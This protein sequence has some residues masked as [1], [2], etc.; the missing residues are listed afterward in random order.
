LRA[1]NDV[2]IKPQLNENGVS[3]YGNGQVELYYDAVKKLETR[4]NGIYVSG[5]TE[6]GTFL[7]TSTSEFRNNVKFDGAT[8][9]V[10]INFFR[11]SNS[12]GFSHN[13]K[14]NFG[15]SGNFSIYYDGSQNILQGDSPTVFR[16]AAGN[17]TL[18][19]L[20]PNG[21]V[22]LY[23]DNTKR[24]ETHAYGSKITASGAEPHGSNAVTRAALN[25][26]GQFGGG[27]CLDD[28]GNGGF[29]HFLSGAGAVYNIST[30][31]GSL[32]TEKCI[33]MNRNGNVE[34]YYDNSKKLATRSNG[35]TVTG[36]TYSDGVTIGNGTAYKYLAGDSNQLQMYHTGSGGNGYLVNSTGTL[37]LGGGTVGL[38]N[39][40]TNAF[41][42]RAIAGGA[43]E[44]YHNG[45]KKF[46]TQSYGVSAT[47]QI[48]VSTSGTTPG[49]SLSDNGRSAWGSGNDLQIYHTGTNTYISNSTGTL[50][51][52]SDT[53]EIKG[54]DGNE[55]HLKTVNNGAVELYYNNT[56]TFET[57]SSGV[58]ATGNI[59]STGNIL[60]TGTSMEVGDF[61]SDG[62]AAVKRIRMTQ[63]GEIHFGDTTTSNFIGI[64]EGTVDQFTD[65]DRI[66]IYYRNELKLYSNNNNARW[67]FKSNG[68]FVP[69][70]DSN[71]D[72]GSS[73]VRIANG[74]FDTLYG[75]G[76][77]LTGINTDLV[78]DTS[79]QLG[80]DLDTNSHHIL[81]D[82]SHAVKFGNDTDLEIQHTG[83]YA[84]THNATGN[85]I[86][87]T[88]GNF[89]L[90]N[91]T[92]SETYIQATANGAVDLYHDNHRKLSTKGSGIEIPGN[93][94][95]EL[96][97][98]NWTGEHAG[99]IQHHSN[100]LYLQGGSNGFKFRHS[101]GTNRWNI[102]S[103]G[104]FTPNANNTYDIGSTSARVRNI[105]TNDLHLSNQGSSND[106]DGT[107]GDWTIQEG[108]SDLFLKNN[109]S[110]K[111]YKFNLM[112][113]S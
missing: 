86:I 109:R 59:V 5:L 31:V 53:Y 45:T 113:V 55:T 62:S 43:A 32:S 83:S 103:N 75:D 108:E 94:A 96:D 81:L 14:A 48:Y 98:G 19:K 30:A 61:G 25:I 60:G 89:Y 87:D 7:A 56:K 93:C 79:P 39:A 73:S 92:G 72:I 8:S 70:T 37:H 95:I 4:S 111:K 10:D 29:T 1:N 6:T 33:E 65:T 49:F 90:R 112:E 80:A 40:A 57:T 16:N 110:G 18:V 11:S 66:G 12:L 34:L 51:T 100:W 46:E 82:D 21:S 91:S 38:T 85:Y 77:N 27:I 24:Y 68:N 26:S 84:H 47:G 23:H 106:V 54:S 2:F 9:G 71:V 28:L 15:G 22:E 20:T 52:L 3:V 88:A 102:D 50:Y 69:N 41:L 105:Y 17:E 74:Y 104:H 107:W 35:I 63:G 101:D 13:A 67:I 97:S 36:Y 99:K 64:T 42:I 44:L 78:A 58:S 76:S